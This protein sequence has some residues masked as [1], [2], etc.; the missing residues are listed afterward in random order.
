MAIPLATS[1]SSLLTRLATL[2]IFTC[3][4]N[5]KVFHCQTYTS[6]MEGFSKYLIVGSRHSK[7]DPETATLF[8]YHDN[9]IMWHCSW[10]YHGMPT[11]G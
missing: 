6:K 1:F 3:F 9:K 7:A 4:C 2:S 11:T 8:D 5:V 10:I